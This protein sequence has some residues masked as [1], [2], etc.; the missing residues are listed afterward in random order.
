MILSKR[1]LEIID[2]S[3]E[4]IAEQGIQGLTIKNIAKKIGIS[5]PAI[6]RHFDSKTDILLTILNNFME[7]ASF[8]GEALKDNE[9]AA[10]SKIE[11]MFSKVIDIFSET[12]SY[13][14]VIFSEEIFKNEEVLKRKI[15][16]ILIM[17]EQTVEN[18][19]KKGQAKGEVR[20]DI[21]YKNLAI[22]VMGSLRFRIKQWD[23]K[24]LK[25]DLKIEGDK[26]INSLKLILKK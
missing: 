11:F 13:I 15:V 26:L 19:I 21:D 23:L 5:E 1:Q 8:M 16:S 2:L 4:I 6:Y 3:I 20:N 9:D 22:I 10:I 14:S 12:P 7:M 18:I 25:G 17:N 24:D